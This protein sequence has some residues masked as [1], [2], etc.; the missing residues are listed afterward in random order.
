MN[1]S[2]LISNLESNHQDTE[3]FKSKLHKYP[4]FSSQELKNLQKLI[5]IK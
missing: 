5:I 2:K 4:G 1:K 3:I